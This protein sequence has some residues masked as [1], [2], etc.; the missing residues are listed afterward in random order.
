MPTILIVDDS[1]FMRQWLR[2][3]IQQQ[4]AYTIIEASNGNAAVQ[5]YKDN[6]PDLVL[7]DMIMPQMTGLVA[8]QAIIDYDPKAKVMMCSSMGT[9]QHVREALHIGA[10]DFVVKP[11]F[12]ALPERVH[13]LLYHSSH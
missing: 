11:F 6:H 12:D 4:K 2:R 7:M 8:L 1:R 3:I 13:K 10:K 5:L 9:K